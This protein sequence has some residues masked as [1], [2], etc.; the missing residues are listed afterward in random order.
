[1]TLL[2]ASHNGRFIAVVTAEDKTVHILEV[3]RLRRLHKIVM[4]KRPSAIAFA[5][6]DKHILCADKFG[7]VYA[8]PTALVPDL[9]EV[10]SKARKHKLIKPAATT[11]T[12]HS[13]GNLRILEEQ[14]K[15]WEKASK[16]NDMKE[17]ESDACFPFEPVLGHVSMITDITT[18][19]IRRETPGRSTSSNFILSADRDEHIR[20]SRHA[21]QAYMIHGFCL[22]HAQFVNKICLMRPEILISGGGDEYICVWLWLENRLLCK[23]N[24]WAENAEFEDLLRSASGFPNPVSGLWPYTQGKKTSG[25]FCACESLPLLWLFYVNSDYKDVENLKFRRILIPLRGNALS[26]SIITA[27]GGKTALVIVNLDNIH[28]PGSASILREQPEGCPR[29][30]IFGVIEQDDGSFHVDGEVG[31]KAKDIEEKC[32]PTCSIPNSKILTQ[33]QQLSGLMH[34]ASSLRKRDISDELV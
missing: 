18:T 13:K 1:M 20:V 10:T 7:D 16:N 8:L 17:G 19:S 34:G 11:A 21:P 26:V 2:A 30:Q 15:S 33:A 5:A 14:I 22:G 27:G 32:L 28:E 29:L 24:H 31:I 9:E 12:V 6:N 25:F 4:P 3:E 23:I